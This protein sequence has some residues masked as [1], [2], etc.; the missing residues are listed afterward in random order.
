ME[1]YSSRKDPNGLRNA[2]IVMV[3]LSLTLFPSKSGK[4]KIPISFFSFSFLCFL[5]EINLVKVV[6]LQ[7]GRC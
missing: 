6:F 3:F 4:K 2:V 1:D 7:V 5:R